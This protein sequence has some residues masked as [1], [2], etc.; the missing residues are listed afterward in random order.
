MDAGLYDL[1]KQGHLVITPN[2]RLAAHLTFSFNQLQQREQLTVWPSPLIKPLDQFLLEYW[3]TLEALGSTQQLLLNN[4]QNFSLWREIVSNYTKSNPLL[5]VEQTAQQALKTWDTCQLWQIDIRSPLFHTTEDS[6]VFQ[7]WAIQFEQ[8][9]KSQHWLTESQLP[10]A[11]SETI[12]SSSQPLYSVGFKNLAHSV[13]ALFEQL[14]VQVIDYSKTSTH[15]PE[16]IAFSEPREEWI[17][18]LRWAAQRAT[19]NPEQTTGIIIPELQKHRDTIQ[20]LSRQVFKQTT[21]EEPNSLWNISVGQPLNQFPIVQHAINILRL[22]QQLHQPQ[23]DLELL[24]QC[25]LSPFTQQAV[26]QR[27]VRFQLDANIRKEHKAKL[28]NWLIKKHLGDPCPIFFSDIDITGKRTYQDWQAV[29][30]NILTHFGWPGEALLTSEEFQCCERFKSLLNDWTSLDLSGQ[31]CD[32]SEAVNRLSWLCQ[33]TVF[34]TKLNTRSGEAAPVQIL[35]LLEAD[36]IKFN[37]LWLTGLNASILPAPI[38]LDPFIPAQLQRKHGLPHTDYGQET[39]YAQTLLDEFITQSD[40][41]IISWSHNDGQTDVQPSSLINNV[42]ETSIESLPLLDYISDAETIHHSQE[43]ESWTD[44]VGSPIE[45]K[46]KTKGGTGVLTHQSACAFRAYARY[47]LNAESIEPVYSGISPAER[48]SLVHKILETIWQ[49]VKDSEALIQLDDEQL[50]QLVRRHIEQAFSEK[51]GLI[52]QYPK[53]YVEL[54]Y[55]CLEQLLEHWLKQEAERPPFKVIATEE[56]QSIQIGPLTLQI[57]ID[58]IDQLSGNANLLIDYKLGNPSCQDWF[59]SRPK[60]PQLPLYATVSP[61]EI[62]NIAF[63]SLHSQNIQYKGISKHDPDI[64]GIRSLEKL[65]LQNTPKPNSWDELQHN[66]KTDLERLAQEHANGHAE[67]NPRDRQTC[68]YCDLTG[69]CR[70]FEVSE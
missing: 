59:G 21:H 19:D 41:A 3:Q 22:Q 48:G 15:P 38:S 12:T 61:Q 57:Q 55:Q 23:V 50:K 34:Q 33:N 40:R 32:F 47:R 1:I 45:I 60:E 9:C 69:F 66:W 43:I 52:A 26:S 7:Q 16:V 8:Q 39:K 64:A 54:E 37:A 2:R 25:L 4:V 14:N 6:K 13:A 29:I 18:A 49:D 30:I 67:V 44:P 31:A 51:S 28:S 46:A 56:R 17:T 42:S 62:H 27:E 63:A 70:V 24:S 36:G 58:R 20:Q 35:G 53:A 5:K 65:R 68:Q 11:L 10:K